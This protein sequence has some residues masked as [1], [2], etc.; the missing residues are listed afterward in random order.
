MCVQIV[1]NKDDDDDD[2]KGDAKSQPSPLFPL[3]NTHT[4]NT[5]DLFN[6]THILT[7]VSPLDLWTNPAEVMELLARCTEKAGW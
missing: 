3:C 7:T 6:C 4:H 2:D 5:Y 1:R